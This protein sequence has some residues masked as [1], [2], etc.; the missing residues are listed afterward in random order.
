MFD[1]PKKDL[2]WLEEQLQ[3]EM[4]QD[5]EFS[6]DWLEEEETD[7][8]DDARELL[9]EDVPRS[10][11]AYDF[12]AEEEDG[13]TVYAPP[14]KKAKTKAEK[15]VKAKKEKGVG[16][17]VFLLLLELVGIAGVVVWWLLWLL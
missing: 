12:D 8:L 14:K 4:S 5:G 2:K 3:K 9:S 15:K 10:R 6:E 1:D 7:W 13:A 11:K 16:G 17:L